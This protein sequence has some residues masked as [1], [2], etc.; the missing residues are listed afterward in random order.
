MLGTGI[1]DELLFAGL[2][3]CRLFF[4]S[5]FFLFQSGSGAMIQIAT[6]DT[7]LN[8]SQEWGYYTSFDKNIDAT[9]ESSAETIQV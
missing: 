1:S 9:R 6:N 5:F 8:V 2:T 4:L 3:S 7:A